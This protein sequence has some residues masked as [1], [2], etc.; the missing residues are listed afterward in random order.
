MA[1]LKSDPVIVHHEVGL[2]VS[3]RQMMTMEVHVYAEVGRPSLTSAGKAEVYSA[4]KTSGAYLVHSC[5]AGREE[6]R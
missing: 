1:Y 3:C 4:A 6:V 2:C 5:G